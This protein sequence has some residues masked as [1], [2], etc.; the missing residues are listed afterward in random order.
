VLREAGQLAHRD[1]AR[2]AKANRPAEH[3]A[4]GPNEVWSWDIT[5]LRSAVKGAFFYLYMAIDVYSRKIVGWEVHIEE[6]ALLAAELIQT[7]ILNE[8]ADARKLVLHAD[9]GGP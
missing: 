4:R 5:Y 2:P 9:N 3:I 7:A 8:R 6:S 1:R